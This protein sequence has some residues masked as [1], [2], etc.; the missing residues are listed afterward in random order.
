M[1]RS[2]KS[3][4]DDAWSIWKCV[5]HSQ[6][7][8]AQI[9]TD[10]RDTMMVS[11]LPLIPFLSFNVSCIFIP[12]CIAPSMCM[13]F[14]YSLSLS[15]SLSIHVSPNFCCFFLH[16]YAATFLYPSYLLPHL[17]LSLFF[18]NSVVFCPLKIIYFTHHWQ[19]TFVFS[20]GLSRNLDSFST[21]SILKNKS[22]LENGMKWRNTCLVSPK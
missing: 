5:M 4:S 9:M 3:W 15:L 13:D 6:L 18:K 17:S 8:N 10:L 7:S 1:F 21:W 2:C 22:R 19:F 14:V 20:A 12:V 11:R 16:V